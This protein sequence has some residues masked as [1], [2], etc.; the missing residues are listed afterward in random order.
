MSKRA[1]VAH[2]ALCMHSKSDVS[3]I[4]L[5][6]STFGPMLFAELKAKENFWTCILTCIIEAKMFKKK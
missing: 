2:I 1:H 6:L 4:C 3:K 5:N